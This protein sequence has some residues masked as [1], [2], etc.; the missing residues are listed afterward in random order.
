MKKLIIPLLTF[1][2]MIGIV[3]AETDVS[4]SNDVDQ[5]QS[6]I[7]APSSHSESTSFPFAISPDLPSNNGY[8]FPREAPPNNAID[9]R[10]LTKYKRVYTRG[11]LLVMVAGKNFTASNEI[12]TALPPT[13]KISIFVMEDLPAGQVLKLAHLDIVGKGDKETT[14]SA[15]AAAGLWAMSQG[16]NVLLITRAGYDRYFQARSAGEGGSLAGMLIEGAKSAAGTVGS[17]VSFTQLRSEHKGKSWVNAIA[18]LWKPL[19][20]EVKNQMLSQNNSVARA[21]LAQYCEWLK[22]HDPIFDADLYGCEEV[23]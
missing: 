22:K 9:I 11:E 15:G 21:K 5:S 3:H 19:P 4:T 14:I 8:H 18:F 13:N 1:L 10:W 12:I 2:V 20:K 7:Y 6:I 17:L 23:K 16:A